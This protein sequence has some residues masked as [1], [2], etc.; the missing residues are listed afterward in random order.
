[1]VARYFSVEEAN[2]ALEVVR[3]LA[4]E[5]VERRRALAELQM[6]QAEF[7]G[8]VAG[9]GGDFDPGELRDVLD[10][11]GEEA[12]AAARCVAGIHEVGAQVKDLDRGLVDFPARRGEEDVL[13]CWRVGEDSVDFWHG[14][15]EGFTGRKPLPL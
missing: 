12:A 13:L 10:Q 6:R 2:E 4:E 1:V 7:E 15:E 5:M 8:R 14:L 3:P 11:M 9:N